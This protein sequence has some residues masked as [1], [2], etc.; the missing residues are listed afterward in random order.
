MRYTFTIPNWQPAT[1]NELMRSV[2]ARI[3]RK[4]EDR[5]FV[6]LYSKMSSVPEAQGKRRVRLIITLGPGQRG[7]DADAYWKSLLDAM[8]HAKL[9]RG[10]SK[11]WVELLPVEYQRGPQKATLIELEDSL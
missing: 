5:E 2:K 7:A 4:K 9:I 8:A 3:R 1:V 11:E 10:D 6:I